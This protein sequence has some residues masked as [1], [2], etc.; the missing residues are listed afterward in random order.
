MKYVWS[1]HAASERLPERSSLSQEE[2]EAALVQRRYVVTVYGEEHHLIW[3]FNRGHLIDVPVMSHE[4]EYGFIPTI[5][6]VDYGS[7]YHE[8]QRAEAERAWL[9]DM[10]FQSPATSSVILCWVDVFIGKTWVKR[11]GYPDAR[12]LYMLLAWPIRERDAARYCDEG[13]VALFRYRQFC[14][15]VRR[16]LLQEAW[17]IKKLVGN[18]K[19]VVHLIKPGARR[20]VPVDFFLSTP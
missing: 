19:P 15:H 17:Y 9:G 18:D 12:D 4:P 1:R 2:I 10:Y 7:V 16:R 8:W 20:Y 6:P 13:V 5:R 14:L 3:D 11:S